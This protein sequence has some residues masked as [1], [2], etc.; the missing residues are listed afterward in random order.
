LSGTA[1]PSTG[2]DHPA[3]S[4]APVAPRPG[5]SASR[6]ALLVLA[7]ALLVVV[8]LLVGNALAGAR[9][10]AVP[11]EDSVDA[12]FARDMQVHHGQA[13]EMSVLLRDR[14]ED[15]DLRQIALDVLLTQQ[16]QQGQM[17]GWLQTWGL[18]QS[19][20]V[21]VM[22]WMSDDP[23]SGSMDGMDMSSPGDEGEA[24]GNPM[25]AMGLAT[26]EQMAAL[27]AADG[28]EAERI[29]LQLMIDHHRGGVAMATVAQE[30]AEQA[31]VRRL[32]ESMVRAQSFEITVLEDL[33]EQRGGPV[34]L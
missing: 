24:S 21:P 2:P 15:P 8:G 5:P 19:S 12:G 20:S 34:D 26:S 22:A 30:R 33:L 3:L 23:F 16:N 25:L 7:G 31:Q 28:V 17:A 13:V 29:Y 32:A 27:E 1:A 18:A 11:A 6:V 9:G 10:A 4:D 14:G